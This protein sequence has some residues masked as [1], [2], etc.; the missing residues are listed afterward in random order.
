MFQ[1]DMGSGYFLARID[2]YAR[3]DCCQYRNN[4]ANFQMLD[5]SGT[6]YRSFTL[7]GNLYQT[8]TF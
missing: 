8:Y 3:N 7:N 2:I 4:G 1:F 5:T 6:V